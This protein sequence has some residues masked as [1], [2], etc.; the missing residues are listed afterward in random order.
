MKHLL[1]KNDIVKA[2]TESDVTELKHYLFYTE[3]IK[4]EENSDGGFKVL[5]I[6]R[7]SFI[8]KTPRI[9]YEYSSE[10]SKTEIFDDI[11]LKDL[12]NRLG[13]EL[14]QRI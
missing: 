4:I 14:Y 10:Y 2:V 6:N 1:V 3:K 11:E 8:D 5:Y 13:Y 7:N 12:C 9:L